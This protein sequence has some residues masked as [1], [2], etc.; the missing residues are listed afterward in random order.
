VLFRSCGLEVRVFSWDSNLQ[1]MADFRHFRSVNKSGK[2]GL[3]G[4]ERPAKIRSWIVPT[5][6]AKSRWE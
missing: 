6:P 5:L 1:K 3:A 2:S 4:T